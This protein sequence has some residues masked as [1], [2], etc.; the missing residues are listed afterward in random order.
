MKKKVFE[1]IGR[2]QDGGAESLVRDY[3]LLI[4]NK[5]FE[6]TVLCEDYVE[7][8]ANYKILKD[9]N[10]NMIVMYKKPF[11]FDKV[12]ARI[13]GKRYI[14]KLFEKV[15]KENKPD[16]IHVHLELLEVLYYARES[17]D[18]IKLFYTCHNPPEQLIGSLKPAESKACKYLI[19]HN[20]LRIIALHDDMAKEID[21]MFNIDNT[22][23][24]RNGIDIDKFRN[25][26]L[27]KE[28][29]RNKLNIPSDAYVIGQIGRFVYQKNPEFSIDVFSKLLEKRNDSYLMLIGRG[30]KKKELIEQAKKLKI[31]DRVMIL[32]GRDDI[33]EL[34]KAMDVFIMP[35]RFEGLGIVLI[36]AQ[37]SGLPCVVSDQIPFEAFKSKN[38]VRL[39]L[40]DDKEK[41]VDALLN[42]QGN[43]DS[44]GKLDDYDMKK[45]IKR[46]EKLYKS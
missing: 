2:I 39:S 7:E 15:I 44:Y 43:I 29:I 6:L 32:S 45:E 12:K 40:N 35:S 16:I 28:K 9:N 31:E 27:S 26:T 5:D 34:L 17:L 23:V 33:P 3:A 1:F 42:P 46:L 36:E 11:F 21:E 41:W 24:I 19:E 25:V 18:G 20:D 14:A 13:F 10:I 8:S 4:D 38:I 22:S 30:K 37:S